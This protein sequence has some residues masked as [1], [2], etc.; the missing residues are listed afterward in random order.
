MLD[1]ED[2]CLATFESSVAI[3]QLPFPEAF[4]QEPAGKVEYDSK[5][6]VSGESGVQL[7]VGVTV[8]VTDGVGDGETVGVGVGG[9]VPQPR[10]IPAGQAAMTWLE[11]CEPKVPT[12]LP[13]V[14]LLI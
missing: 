3:P 8:G 1:D 7:G 2:D 5:L 14:L 13:P 12:A 11:Y 6:S 4:V 10:V 9:T